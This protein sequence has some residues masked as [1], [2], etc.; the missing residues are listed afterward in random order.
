MPIYN[1]YEE[2]M[3]AMGVGEHTQGLKPQQIE[4]YRF[5]EQ[6][7]EKYGQYDP[8]ILAN[9]AHYGDES[10]FASDGLICA[11]CVYYQNNACEIVQGN[12]APNG[13]CKFWIIPESKLQ[14]TTPVD[15]DMIL[16]IQELLMSGMSNEEIML[17]LPNITEEDIVMAAAE[18]ARTN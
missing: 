2:A 15:A 3:M 12:I 16:Q 18:A 11:N 4:Q 6:Q 8:G 13:I 7:V 10:P 9:G 5:Y 17:E 14:N 1:S